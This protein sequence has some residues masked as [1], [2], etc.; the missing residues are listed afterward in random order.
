MFWG[1]QLT[2]GSHWHG[3]NI[4]TG[5]HT[6]HGA[7]ILH[8]GKIDLMVGWTMVPV[9]IGHSG[10]WSQWSRATVV[11]GH[12]G[13]WSQWSLATVVTGHS[14]H[15]HS[16]HWPLWSLVT[17]VTGHS[18][19][20]SQWSLFTVVTGPS[21]HW[22]QWSVVTVVTG[23]S[24][25]WS[26]WSLFTVITGHCGHWPQWSL[27]TVVTGQSG[28]WSQ[29][30]L[31]TVVTGHSG[32]WSQWSLATVATDHSGH[33]SQWSLIT[34]V[35]GQSGY[36][37]QWSLVSLQKS[38]LQKVH[39]KNSKIN[40]PGMTHR[41]RIDLIIAIFRLNC[42]H[43]WS[44]LIILWSLV[45][46]IGSQGHRG[47][48]FLHQWSAHVRTHDLLRWISSLQT[49]L[50]ERAGHRFV[51]RLCIRGLS[52]ERPKL[53]SNENGGSGKWWIGSSRS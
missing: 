2:W 48:R 14:G 31:A 28:H 35:T 20:W 41:M 49:R 52:E 5:A 42:D 21:G 10:H 44:S 23:H 38:D 39:Y 3:A 47:S 18:G 37:P 36:W 16:G 7:N 50:S 4:D 17:V 13:H 15:C 9:V 27:V 12:C 25:H 22:L 46:G 34:V 53:N 33:W 6:W 11:T 51:R 24:G 26:Q 45:G 1:S 29:W 30:S 32:H 40:S 8:L 43:C 19:H